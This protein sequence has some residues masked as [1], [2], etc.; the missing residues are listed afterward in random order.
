VKQ[1][2]KAVSPLIATIILIA[3]VVSAGLVVYSLTSGLFGSLAPKHTFDIVNVDL[4]KASTGGMLSITVKNTGSATAQLVKV[5]IQADGGPV[6][7]VAGS[8]KNF[9]LI[10]VDGVPG[11]WV[12]PAQFYQG[13]VDV[14]SQ[15][16]DAT[17][18]RIS[19]LSDLDSLVRNPPEGAVVI[20]C[21]GE[22]WPIPSGWA[23]WQDYFLALAENVKREGW[24][25]SGGRAYQFFY[26]CGGMSLTTGPS[27]LQ[28]FMS[29]IGASADSGYDLQ[30]SPTADGN[31][32]LS[33]FRLT[34]Q[35][36]LRCVRAVRFYGVA[37]AY[38]FYGPASDRYL[39]S[40]VRMGG[41]FFL[42]YGETDLD[43]R[44][45]GRYASAFAYWLST[46]AQL[47]PGRTTSLTITGLQVTVGQKYAVTVTVKWLDGSVSSKSLAVACI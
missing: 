11:C 15:A 8:T 37:P 41:G 18:T 35:N 22:I 1:C 17:V 3:I 19:T 14:L 32:A 44:T 42:S 5:S 24:V 45:S 47:Q 33:K 26:V 21:H 29:S 40:A 25:L 39:A 31:D 7:Y 30:F 23:T 20:N 13:C 9:Y 27:G 6:E 10:Y 38:V 43:D 46:A 12:D 4:V 28:T 34:P 2:K 36:P 16:S